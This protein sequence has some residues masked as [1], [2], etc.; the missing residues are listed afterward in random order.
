[1]EAERPR[2]TLSRAVAHRPALAMRL[3]LCREYP[4]RQRVVELDRAGYTAAAKCLA[5]DLGAL[6]VPLRYPLRHRRRSTE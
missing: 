1:M 3:V 6:V 5:D 2:I 4:Q